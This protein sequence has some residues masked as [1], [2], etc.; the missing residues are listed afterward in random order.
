M[1][2]RVT[3]GTGQV[4]F[5]E[6]GKRGIFCESQFLRLARY[7]FRDSLRQRLVILGRVQE[8]NHAPMHGC[9]VGSHLK[10]LA[11]GTQGQEPLGTGHRELTSEHLD[12]Q[13][14]RRVEEEG[15]HID[16]CLVER[17]LHLR[18]RL[19][20]GVLVHRFLLGR[21]TGFLPFAPLGLRILLCLGFGLR[22]RLRLRLAPLTLL[23]LPLSCAHAV[24]SLIRCRCLLLGFA[25]NAHV[26]LHDPARRSDVEV[27]SKQ[28]V[29]EPDHAYVSPKRHLADAV[30]V[31]VELIFG[32]VVEVL[33]N[34]HEV[35]QRPSI[36]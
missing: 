21:S 34:V 9:I 30:G 18:Q 31:K 33:L 3:L 13:L 12:P 7:H 10:G 2:H 24:A 15:S 25:H 1:G 6:F 28:G 23:L 29:L 26:S 32:E 16:C 19:A 22:P 5:V 27:L 14:C 20:V 36:V 35:L 8:A 11:Q 17:S 4:S